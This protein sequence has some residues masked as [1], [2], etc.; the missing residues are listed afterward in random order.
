MYRIKYVYNH[1]EVF[2]TSGRFLF[3]ADNAGEVEE[4]LDLLGL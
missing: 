1:Y 2:D 4:G 3:S